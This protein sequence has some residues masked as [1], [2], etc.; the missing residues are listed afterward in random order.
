MGCASLIGPQLS[1]TLKTSFY[2]PGLLCLGCTA[3]AVS[4][5]GFNDVVIS[6]VTLFCTS[7]QSGCWDF[8]LGISR[9]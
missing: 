7:G 8:Y 1:Q 3:H 4:C 9:T 6:L 5:L 2:F